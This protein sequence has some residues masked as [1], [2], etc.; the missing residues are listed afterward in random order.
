MYNYSAFFYIF[1]IREEDLWPHVYRVLWH[2]SL[3]I[4]TSGQ[5][6]SDCLPYTGPKGNADVFLDRIPT[7]TLSTS[8]VHFT[9]TRVI[10]LRTLNFAEAGLAKS[11]RASTALYWKQCRDI[12]LAKSKFGVFKT[13]ATTVVVRSNHFLWVLNFILMTK[14]A[15]SYYNYNL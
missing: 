9:E 8:V 13:T 1:F 4:P 2:E 7:F 12:Y 14:Y 3:S 11:I 6:V 5:H 15:N 10:L